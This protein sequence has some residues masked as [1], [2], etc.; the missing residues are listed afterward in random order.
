M[1]KRTIG[2]DRLIAVVVNYGL[3]AKKLRQ[4]ERYESRTRQMNDIGFPEEPNK[5]VDSSSSDDAQHFI[6][7]ERFACRSGCGNSQLNRVVIALSRFAG[8][9]PG[10]SVGNALNAADR[11]RPYGRANEDVHA[12]HL[13]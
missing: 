2:T 3:L 1:D 11:G 13:E 5:P 6:S 9:A 12:K 10:E 7:L 8:E 4:E